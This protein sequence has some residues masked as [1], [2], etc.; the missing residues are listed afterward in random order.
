MDILLPIAWPIQDRAPPGVPV[1][2][3]DPNWC[4]G[5][6]AKFIVSIPALARPPNGLYRVRPDI[7]APRSRKVHVAVAL[8]PL[9]LRG[10]RSWTEPRSPNRVA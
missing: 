7:L 8:C 3:A 2:I 6:P 9:L 5:I 10:I 1:L 4:A